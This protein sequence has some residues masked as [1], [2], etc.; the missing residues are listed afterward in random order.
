VPFSIL[1]AFI[2][3]YLF[4]AAFL[5]WIPCL[6]LLTLFNELDECN[7]LD[8]Y[9]TAILSYLSQNGLVFGNIVL[10]TGDWL[11]MEA[12]MLF[13]VQNHGGGLTFACP[14]SSRSYGQESVSCLKSPSLEAEC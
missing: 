3:S 6:N 14:W 4:Y 11:G 10:R 8:L 5:I 7:G 13:V 12:G 1:E 9:P 2:C